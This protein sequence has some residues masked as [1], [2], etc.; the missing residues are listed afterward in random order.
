LPYGQR[1]GVEIVDRLTVIAHDRFDDV[2]KAARDP[3]SLI[4]IR[5]T[6][7][8]G[9]GG[10]VSDVG[11]HVVESLSNVET[12]LTG[13]GGTFEESEQKPYVF[14]T[15]KEREVAK[16]TWDVIAREFERKIKTGIEKLETPEIQAEITRIVKE[17]MAP[18]Q[19]TFET[20]ERKTD[21]A[22][23]VAKVTKQ[24]VMNTISIPEIVVLPT[25]DVNFGFKDFDLSN[26]ETIAKQPLSDQIMV[27]RLRDESRAF[28]ARTVEGVKEERLENYLVRH[29]MDL[30]QVD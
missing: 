26:L 12:S 19:G 8:V 7:I 18:E 13:K 25:S 1:T 9:A 29:L 5:K 30:P 3:D 22:A 17:V 21:V 20:F 4:S 24:L 2:I 10:D 27:Q 23:T 28:L 14:E 16:V 6:V 11:A 15:Q